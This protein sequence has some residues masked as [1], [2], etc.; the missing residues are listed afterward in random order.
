MVA[1]SYCIIALFLIL[2]LNC[3]A[4]NT[5]NVFDIR[6]ECDTVKKYV[7]VVLFSLLL[8]YGIVGNVLLMVV[9][10][11]RDNLYSHSFVL[12]AS[13]IIVCSF[14]SFI[15]Q[16]AIVLLEILKNKSS[17]AYKSTWVSV[18]FATMETF[19]FIAM[20]HFTFLL[21]VNRLVAISLP[22]FSSIFESTKFYFLL[23]LAWTSSFESVSI[24]RSLIFF[25]A[26]II[27]FHWPINRLIL[28]RIRYIWTL[29]IP[30]A[31]FI[32][33]I[34]IFC[35]MRNKRK[36]ISDICNKSGYDEGN[37]I[38]TNK[39]E[40]MMLIQAVFVCG[41]IEIQII[42]FS[43]LSKLVVK[44]ADREV[45]IL[46]NIFINCYVIFCATVLPTTN[47]IFVKRFRESLKRAFVELLSKIKIVKRIPTVVL[48]TSIAMRKI[49]PIS[50]MN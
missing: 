3:Y 17:A 15:P 22:K 41:A 42:C 35:S 20:L 49:H 40:R 43:F 36:N 18:I 16:V 13:Q 44:L 27:T 46:V 32:V 6:D 9:F 34:P 19:S 47:L 28:F 12:I 23:F 29:A 50:H 45:E 30:I 1:H 25:F 48:T 26:E 37:M 11:A 21:A 8:L 7:A 14:L 4:E 33:Y 39:Y 31:M 10:C 38:A 5:T 2:P 24:T